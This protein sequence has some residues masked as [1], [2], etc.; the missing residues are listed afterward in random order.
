MFVLVIITW[1]TH[2]MNKYFYTCINDRMRQ[3]TNN[4][5]W[6]LSEVNTSNLS[7]WLNCKLNWQV[8]TKHDLPTFYNFTNLY[9]CVSYKYELFWFLNITD[10][11]ICV[12]GTAKW[13]LI[14]NF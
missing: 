2:N 9:L 6:D 12:E 14:C 1:N 11:Q 7:A 3:T 10:T 5:R 8:P 13:S 4:S